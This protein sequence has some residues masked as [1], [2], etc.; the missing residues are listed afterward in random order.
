MTAAYT[1]WLPREALGAGAVERVLSGVAEQWSRKW[2][3]GR[4]VQRLEHVAPTVAIDDLQF[5]VLEDGLAVAL[6]NGSSLAI[7]RAMLDTKIDVGKAKST[8]LKLFER[9]A[10]GCLDDLCAR[11]TQAFKLAKESRWRGGKPDE[12]L[13]F[14]GARFCAL[15][16]AG[17]GAPLMYLFVTLDLEVDFIRSGLPP[18]RPIKLEP[19]AAGLAGQKVQVSAFLGRSDLTIADLSGLAK[20]DVVVLDRKFD[21]PVD[22]AL[23]GRVK[24]GQCRVEQEGAQLR[25]KIV[26]PLSG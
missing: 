9:L 1:A 7:A 16:F 5:R 25:L 17:L 11:L 18:S 19:L 23:D 13:P 3:I 4:T 26:E 21:S 10:A 15:G 24:A 8:D 22:L 14:D 2:F 12:G 20:G 6:H